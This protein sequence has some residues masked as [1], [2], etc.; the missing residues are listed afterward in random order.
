MHYIITAWLA[1][2]SPSEVGR[3]ISRKAYTA[4]LL[5]IEC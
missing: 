2:L 1:K 3:S 4:T 5:W